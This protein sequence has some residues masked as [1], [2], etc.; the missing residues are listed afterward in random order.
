M[1]RPFNW[2]RSH[3]RHR[4]PRSLTRHFSTS[5]RTY[6]Y[7]SLIYWFTDLLKSWS[8]LDRQFSNSRLSAAQDLL[9]CRRLLILFTVDSATLSS[10]LLSSSSSSSYFADSQFAFTTLLHFLYII[11]HMQTF[12]TRV[13]VWSCSGYDY[14]YCYCYCWQFISADSS[15]KKRTHKYTA[16]KIHLHSAYP[17]I[18][19]GCMH[20][21]LSQLLLQIIHLNALIRVFIT[22]L[23]LW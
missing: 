20:I 10:S 5:F 2:M 21:S 23:L 19:G 7:L 15:R 12:W 4:A 18:V 14:C 11:Y 6:C 17:S 13:S 16:Y 8:W 3:Q 1:H 9:L 22:F